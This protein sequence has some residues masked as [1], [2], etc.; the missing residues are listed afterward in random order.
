MRNSQLNLLSKGR[1]ELFTLWEVTCFEPPSKRNYVHFLV[2]NMCTSESLPG[3]PLCCCA[4]RL[5]L[6][7]F[8]IFSEKNHQIQDCPLFPTLQLTQAFFM[9]WTHFLLY[10]DKDLL[11]KVNKHRS[12][13]LKKMALS[14]DVFVHIALLL[15]FY[16][17]HQQYLLV[18]GR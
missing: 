4:C 14:S 12:T 1:A 3:V 11:S 17:S 13:T 15:S 6:D 8:C 2:Q 16:L 10:I 9:A 18:K 7:S 5:S